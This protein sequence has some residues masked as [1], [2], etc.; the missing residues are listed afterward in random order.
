MNTSRF[1]L[2]FFFI[3]IFGFS[4][5]QQENSDAKWTKLQEKDG[6]TIFYK[7]GECNQ[8]K[9]ASYTEDVYLKFTNTTDQIVYVEW[10]Y[11]VTYGDR[12]FNCDGTNEEMK[13]R[14]K[15]EPNGSKE[16]VC[17][18]DNSFHLRIFSKFTKMENKETMK[19]FHV[20][21]L[22]IEPYVE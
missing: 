15:I 12:C 4:F 11:D 17:G 2:S 21:I 1:L 20:K 3:A 16:G 22:S 18:D 13:T 8:P 9:F 14:M 19:E 6:I 7:K 5:A 10:I